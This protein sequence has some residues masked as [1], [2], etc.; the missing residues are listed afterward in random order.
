MDNLNDI[1]LKPVN[2][3]IT[4][5]GDAMENQMISF[6]SNLER[7]NPEVI[8][9]ALDQVPEIVKTSSEAIGGIKDVTKNV[10]QSN[11][12]SVN[13]VYDNIDKNAE[14][15]RKIMAEGNLS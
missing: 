4:K 5:E 3:E 9:K 10:L 15:I 8:K 12:N 6:S 14:A 2:D 13:H 7:Q 1:S 11:D